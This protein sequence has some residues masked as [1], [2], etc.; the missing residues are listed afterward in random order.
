MTAEVHTPATAGFRQVAARGIAYGL[1]AGLLLGLLDT[2]LGAGALWREFDDVW[3]WLPLAAR[4]TLLPVGPGAGLGLLAAALLL[5]CHRLAQ[6]QALGRAGR[7]E[8]WLGTYLALLGLPGLLWL[9][10]QVFA[11]PQAQK[12]PGRPLL[13]LLLVVAG[14]FSIR[15]LAQ[16][17]ARTLTEAPQR[18]LVFSPLAG[19]GALLALLADRYVLPRLYPWFHSTLQL[20]AYLALLLALFALDAG[21]RARSRTSRTARPSLRHSLLWLLV[22]L[23]SCLLSLSLL[24]R[25]Y[26]ASLLRSYILEQ[27]T[28]AAALMRPY[29]A[30]RAASARGADPRPQGALVLP[31]E[32]AAPPPPVP[33]GPRLAGRDVFLITVDALRHDRL[34]L[35]PTVRGLA[36]RGVVFE[37]AYTQVPHTSFALATLLTG[38]PVY[39][40][41]T[42]GQDAASHETLPTVL[43]RFRYKTAAFYPPSVFYIEHD[44]LKRLEDSAY[45]FEYVKYEYLSGARRTDQV[46]AFLETEKPERAFVWVHY[47][48][49]HEPYEPHPDLPPGQATR[50]GDSDSRRYDGEIA[51]VDREI[52]RLLAYLQAQRPGALVLFSADH[53]EEFS[54]HGGRYHGTTLYEE[55]VHVPLLLAPAAAPL[56]GPATAAGAEPAAATPPPSRS[57]LLAENARLL[58]PRRLSTPV[59][60]LDMAPTLLGLL[61]IERSARMRGRDLSPWLLTG[62]SRLPQGPIF[63]EIGRKK[64]VVLGSDK[65]ICDLSTDACQ[66]FDLARDP[67][68]RHNLI[69]QRPEVLARL[70]GVLDRSLAEARRYESDGPPP[71]QGTAAAGATTLDAQLL[72]RAKLG[73]RGVLPALLDSLGDARLS[74]ESR[75][76]LLALVGP[77]LA[78]LPPPAEPSA[79]DPLSPLATPEHLGTLGRL[80]TAAGDDRGSARWAAVSLLRLSAPAHSAPSAE[81]LA[82]VRALL[83][84]AAADAESRLCAALALA[85]LPSCRRPAAAP[86]P[87]EPDCL[88]LWLESGVLPAVL[89]LQ[90]ADRARPLIDLIGGSRDPRALPALLAQLDNVLSRA[91]LVRALGT[92]GQTAAV[93]ALRARLESDPYVHVRVAA[94]TALGQLAPRSAAARSALAQATQREREPAVKAAIT[95]ALA[96]SK[97]APR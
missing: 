35:M 41:L 70:R 27:T 92:L 23:G 34:A 2:G 40:L 55:Q 51:Y 90:D 83:A 60:L 54:E 17:L 44:K 33:S 69:A 49:P 56:P 81:S 20:A 88:A 85:A 91:D 48:E 3:T 68:E 80:L 7:S 75:R 21:W 11:G 36:E 97:P 61:D 77:L 18:L 9:T 30:G 96:G 5:A 82:A 45:G 58:P 31:S 87:A 10:S 39:A 94:A 16:G 50:A 95:A 93:P 71:L 78:T 57:A 12:L 67:G 62:E 76:R 25:L 38:K 8:G 79:V 24:G 1:G 37:R 66:L 22:L 13:S 65:L 28:I 52:G 29:A 73:D 14:M 89:A 84:D 19:L 74:D 47:L 42:L 86:T 59:G 72:S 46:L 15:G 6:R 64:M 32:E 4:Q 63:A 26:R 53:G 43:R